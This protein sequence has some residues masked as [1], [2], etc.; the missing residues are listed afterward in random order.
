MAGDR[1]LLD[2]MAWNL[3]ENAV[4][5]NRPGGFVRIATEGANGTALLRV[6]N[7][8]PVVPAGAVDRLLEPFQRL[9]PGA[10]EGAGVGLSLVRAV[11]EVHGGSISLGARAG[12]EL[13][14]EVRLPP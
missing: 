7:S 10:G 12:G 3:A 5:Y 14:A 8:G 9:G 1:S 6:E 2:R 4:L 13:I 11:A